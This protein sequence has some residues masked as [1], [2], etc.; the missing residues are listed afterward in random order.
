[1]LCFAVAACG[2]KRSSGGGIANLDI[3]D[4]NEPLELPDIDFGG[5][6]FRVLSAGNQAQNDFDFQEESSL[7][8]D[9]ARGI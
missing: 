6:E 5:A 4:E 1:M 3:N 9:N 8:L 2:P 7:A